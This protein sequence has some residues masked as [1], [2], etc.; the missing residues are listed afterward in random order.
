MERCSTPLIGK[1]KSKPQWD[2]SSYPIGWPLLNNKTKQNKKT[3]KTPENNQCWRWC[4]EIKTLV[5]CWWL[6]KLV[7]SLWKTE[8]RFL[9]KLRIKLPFDQAIFLWVFIQKNWYRDLW[10][11]F[12]PPCSQQH[13]H[14]RQQVETT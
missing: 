6:C 14:N 7:Q 12:A 1:Y 13:I 10:E 11:L 2:T 8:W 5:H 3:P 4:G 9:Q